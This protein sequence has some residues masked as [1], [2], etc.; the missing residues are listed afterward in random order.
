MKSLKRIILIAVITVAACL[1]AACGGDRA[2]EIDEGEEEM[3]SAVRLET[4]SGL[5]V[6]GDQIVWGCVDNA[7]KYV[8]NYKG[9]ETETELN[10]FVLAS[11]ESGAVYG[12]KVKAVGD[13]ER[14]LDS[15]WAICVE[16]GY[17]K[18]GFLYRL[19]ENGSGYEFHR[20]KATEATLTGIVT[21]PDYFNGLP[22]KRLAQDAFMFHTYGM[23]DRLPVPNYP[24]DLTNKVTTAVVFPSRL[25]SIGMYALGGMIKVEEFKI[26]DSVTEIESSAFYMCMGL[27]RVTLPKGL[28]EIP[29]A[30]FRYCAL[31]EID[32]PDTI[33]K[34]G[35]AAFES[36]TQIGEPPSPITTC[37]NLKNVVIPEGVTYIGG[38]AFFGC[39]GL[40]D[41]VLPDSLKTLE[42]KA[43]WCCTAL[44]NITF[45]SEL[46]YIGQ[47]VLYKTEWLDSQSDG[48]VINGSAVL[49]YKGKIEDGAV[50]E[51]P[52]GIKCVSGAIFSMQKSAF[53]VVIPNGI[54]N[55]GEKVF[56]N[57]GVCKVNIPDDWTEIPDYFL[58][59]CSNIT[60]IEIPF[61]ITKIGASA[62]NSTKIREVVIPK[63]VTEIGDSAFGSCT[64]LERVALPSGLKSIGLKAFN[65]CKSLTEIVIPKSVESIYGSFTNCPAL[66]AVYYEGSEEQFAACSK[67]S[68][69]SSTGVLTEIK[70]KSYSDAV[71]Y[72]YSESEPDYTDQNSYWRYADGVATPWI[73]ETE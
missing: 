3:P 15:E 51:I 59:L 36:R 40:T 58:S 32:F 62:F 60:T 49:S 16:F 33:E 35:G 54:V 70:G 44:K 31:E 5:N 10:Y 18:N 8:V 61:G 2:T 72:Y 71:I 41:V 43:F 9:K 14:Y 53:E 11:E 69:I 27:K 57:T 46:E 56:T 39:E 55:F 28:T 50:I 42:S 7:V 17:D 13:G 25:E 12:F 64:A 4:P 66:A 73:K 38:S 52:S 22:V 65:N 21:I 23:P 68:Y 47:D 30:C 37:P 19:L 20:G 6:E 45:P 1:F 63:S 67:K 48:L 26:P 24:D 34:I 29:S